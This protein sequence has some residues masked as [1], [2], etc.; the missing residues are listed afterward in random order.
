MSEEYK[1]FVPIIPPSATLN[2]EVIKIDMGDARTSATK[3]NNDDTELNHPDNTPSLPEMPRATFKGEPLIMDW[4]SEQ[5]HQDDPA[6]Q[7]LAKS[8]ST[9]GN[10]A[11][12]GV[13]SFK[14]PNRGL[15]YKPYD[16]NH[17]DF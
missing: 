7:K 11:I 2:G 4:A 9:I 13:S 8:E 6:E 10:A 12:G 5:V 3:Q 15:P 17:D 16:R 1:P 14:N